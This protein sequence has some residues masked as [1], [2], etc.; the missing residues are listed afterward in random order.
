MKQEIGNPGGLAGLL[1]RLYAIPAC[2]PDWFLQ[3][4]ARIAIAPVFFISGRAKVTGFTVTDS[5]IFLFEHEFGLP[6]PVLAAHLAALA[7]NVLPILLVAGFATR[8]SA[9]ALFVMTIVIQFIYPGGFWNHH[10]LWFFLLLFIMARGP[11]CISLDH[12]VAKR[13]RG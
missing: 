13:F 11:G 5:T 9:L 10:S 1:D 6:M 12:L 2:V 3:L 4:F 8:L 7:E